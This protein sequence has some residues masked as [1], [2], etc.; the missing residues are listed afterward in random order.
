MTGGVLAQSPK[1]PESP[2]GPNDVPL[3]LRAHALH[4]NM[5]ANYIEQLEATIF[6][7]TAVDGDGKV[8][9]KYRRILQSSDAYKVL[10][11][12][13]KESSFVSERDLSAAGLNRS[14]CGRDLTAHT[15]ATDLSHTPYEVGKLNS[16][17]RIIGLAA[18]AYHLVDRDLVHGT[19]VVLKGTCILHN[20]MSHLSIKNILQLEN[21]A[22]SARDDSLQPGFGM[23]REGR[24]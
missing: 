18:A 19:R 7:Q 3:L 4:L 16:R 23:E 20:F 13:W 12:I 2:S 21:W 17:V 24:K 9:L 8:L 1:K 15:L 14:Y 22:L 6:C 10:V 11:V 5:I